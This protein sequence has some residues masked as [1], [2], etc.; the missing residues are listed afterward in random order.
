MATDDARIDTE[1]LIMAALA[2]IEFPQASLLELIVRH[3]PWHTTDGFVAEPFT[4]P[5]R[6]PGIPW[7]ACGVPEVCSFL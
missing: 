7:I 3:Y 4:S 2:D 5:D 1:P 6:V